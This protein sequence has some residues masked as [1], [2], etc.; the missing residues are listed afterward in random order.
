[1][2]RYQKGY[3]NEGDEQQVDRPWLQSKT[4]L[5]W[6]AL[7]A[8]EPQICSK[9]NGWKPVRR[10]AERTSL[11]EPTTA[12]TAVLAQDEDLQLEALA[13][14]L[15]SVQL[16]EQQ[17]RQR[18][19]FSLERPQPNSMPCSWNLDLDLFQ[20]LLASDSWPLAATPAAGR[21]QRPV[22]MSNLLRS[23]LGLTRHSPRAAGQETQD[24]ETRRRGLGG[25]HHRPLVSLPCRGPAM[26]ICHP[27]AG[28]VSA[29]LLRVASTL[30]GKT[31]CHVV[32]RATCT[33]G[34]RIPM[35]L[36]C[37]V[38]KVHQRSWSLAGLWRR[39]DVTGSAQ[40]VV[41]QNACVEV[42]HVPRAR[43]VGEYPWAFCVEWA[44]FIK[45]HGALPASG[46]G[47]T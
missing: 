38:G 47:E 11:A 26:L 15:F 3:T 40:N 12:G 20:D 43:V 1:M 5:W 7:K 34:W 2:S 46:G 30:A 4:T 14:L 27:F 25:S 39:R 9:K 22:R 32:S 35:G 17:L 37:R 24:L 36:L 28:V 8:E 41:M 16:C 19:W 45:G 33:S 31:G 44:K 42:S 13:H 10:L 21:W 23:F 18:G 29:K 6:K